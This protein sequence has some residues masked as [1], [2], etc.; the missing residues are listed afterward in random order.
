[1]TLVLIYSAISSFV[2]PIL[3][4]AL[5]VIMNRSTTPADL[6]NGWLSNALLGACL[7]LFGFLC[8]LQLQET[9]AGL[10]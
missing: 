10:A 2:L 1:M 9:V 7:A 8:L 5:L 3:S 4:T 6:R